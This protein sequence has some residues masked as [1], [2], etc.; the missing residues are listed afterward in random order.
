MSAS[1]GLLDRL[2]DLGPRDIGGSRAS[3]FWRCT[4]T[5]Q[6]ADSP[7]TC[8]VLS[9]EEFPSTNVGAGLVN[10]GSIFRLDV[11][12]LGLGFDL[13]QQLESTVWAR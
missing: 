13:D 3:V 10:L 9:F 11:V 6:R 2:G 5:C 7:Q 8:L 4:V 1:V 12:E